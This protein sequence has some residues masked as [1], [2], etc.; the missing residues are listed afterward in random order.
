MHL[1][2][3]RGLPGS[4]KSTLAEKLMRRLDAF[5][6]EAD[7]YHI[8]DGEY[9]FDINNLADAHEWCFNHTRA[10][11]EERRQVIVSNTFT[12]WREMRQY[13]DLVEGMMLPITIIECRAD[14]GN[15]H[16]VPV[17]TL[18]KMKD[19]FAGEQ[20]FRDRWKERYNF[21]FTGPYLYQK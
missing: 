10:A 13:C 6:I 7:H 20:D 11:L 5:H 19:R 15:I 18:T 9:K 2:L 1:T 14:F 3:I 12:T 8:V 17:E 4:G 21:E 16:N